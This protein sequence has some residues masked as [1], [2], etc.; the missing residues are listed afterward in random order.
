MLIVGN[1]RVITR[2]E[3]VPF[4]E[5][6]AVAMEG[7]VICKVGNLEELKSE[8]PQAEY[9][10]AKGGVIMPAMIDPGD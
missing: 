3:T 1:G 9:I 4:M 5:S 6:G 10:D 8:Y 7:N 2:N